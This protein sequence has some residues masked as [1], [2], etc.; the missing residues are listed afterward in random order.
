MK[1]STTILSLLI[2]S[3]SLSAVAQRT[4]LDAGSF[5]T[6]SG[7]L[8]VRT[9]I[10]KFT[11]VDFQSGIDLKPLAIVQIKIVRIIPHEDASNPNSNPL[12]VY[13]AMVLDSKSRPFGA[14]LTLVDRFWAGET[15]APL[16]PGHSYLVD[17]GEFHTRPGA[18]AAPIGTLFFNLEMAEPTQAT[19]LP[20]EGS[21]GEV[22][23]GALADALETST[24]RDALEI[25]AIIGPRIPGVGTPP[26]WPGKPAPLTGQAL[27]IARIAD[28]TGDPYVRLAA[29]TL[30]AEWSVAGSMDRYLMA[31][32][33][34]AKVAPASF[35][36]AE[37]AVVKGQASDPKFAYLPATP[38]VNFDGVAFAK[39]AVESRNATTQDL[40]L[41]WIGKD[42]LSTE[43]TRIL[44]G[45][46]VGLAP[47]GMTGLEWQGHLKVVC[48]ALDKNAGADPRAYDPPSAYDPLTQKY[49]LRQAIGYWASKLAVAHP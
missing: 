1:T 47:K 15:P 38:V 20:Q 34:V 24:G 33:D 11:N 16:L 32:A 44:G 40:M 17:L 6:S 19:R 42:Q 13:E 4:A 28:S 5:G 21:S 43:Q 39:A 25:G 27:R 23:V 36:G 9:Q 7:S 30:L 8:T 26:S 22:F 14:S 45:Q 3:C 49:S 12:R 10:R 2:A 35:Q 48:L 46:L 37:L 29:R 31:L 18:K 41:P